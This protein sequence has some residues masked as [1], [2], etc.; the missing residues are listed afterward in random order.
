MSRV[1][2]N[3]QHFLLVLFNDDICIKKLADVFQLVLLL[4]IQNNRLAVGLLCNDDFLSLRFVGNDGR[5]WCVGLL[6]QRQR[7]ILWL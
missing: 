5:L 4:L 7:L 2:V 6:N 1:L 3:K